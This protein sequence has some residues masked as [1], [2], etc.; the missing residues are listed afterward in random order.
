MVYEN[1]KF[2]GPY[3]NKKDNRL[4]CVLVNKTNKKKLT[5]S[6]P[7]YLIEVHLNRYLKESETVNH[8][9]GNPLNNELDNLTVIDRREHCFC[10]AVKNR[11]IKVHC[12]LCG[13]PF[14]IKGSKINNR[15]RS[16]RKQSGYFC[17]KSCSGKYEKLIQ[18]GLKMP[19]EKV[20]RIIP[21][22]YRGKSALGETQDVDAG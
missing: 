14:L 1:F 5:I 10:D 19:N 2:Y 4:R 9:D 22:K 13:K 17:S 15:N 12:S 8:L 20:E 18:L 7:K 16:D 6:Y 3:L 21:K 11:D